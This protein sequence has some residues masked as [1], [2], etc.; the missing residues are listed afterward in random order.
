MISEIF[1]SIVIVIMFLGF[2]FH[3]KGVFLCKGYPRRHGHGKSGVRSDKHYKENWTLWQRL[4]WIPVFK[5]SY[6]SDFRIMAYLSYIHFAWCIIC[7]ICTVIGI[8]H[9]LDSMVWKYHFIAYAA[10]TLF[11]YIH[12]DDVLRADRKPRFSEKKKRRK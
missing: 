9:F 4:L 2:E 12:D 3:A 10:F 6:P 7:I 8:R 11:R 1:F 5:E